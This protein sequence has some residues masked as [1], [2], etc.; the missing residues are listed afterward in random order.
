MAA[1]GAEGAARDASRLDLRAPAAL[2]GL[3]DPGDDRP[4]GREGG[5]TQMQEGP[6]RAVGPASGSG[7]ARGERWGRGDLPSTFSAAATA[8]RPGA[9]KA[10]A[11]R[12]DTPRRVGAVNAPAGERGCRERRDAPGEGSDRLRG[13]PS[14]G[15]RQEGRAIFAEPRGDRLATF[16]LAHQVR[17]QKRARAYVPP[18]ART[19]APLAQLRPT[20]EKDKRKA[21]WRT[22]ARWAR[23][24]RPAPPP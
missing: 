14:A 8:R 23:R 15:G 1:A 22:G 24:G 12:T 3:V 11:T 19:G 7:W 13:G 5:T 6:A 18:S 17:V 20:D 4:F 9:R 16:R 21:L 10:P 2:D